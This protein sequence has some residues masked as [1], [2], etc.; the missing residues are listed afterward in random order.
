MKYFH[1][2]KP[3]GQILIA[4]CA[5]SASIA[6]FSGSSFASATGAAPLLYDYEFTGT[7]GTVVNSAPSGPA[8]PLT[9]DGT[10]SPVATGVK[11]SGDT[12]GNESV[13]YGKPTTGYTLSEPKTAAVAVGA[14]IQYQRPASGKC[15][16][17]APNLS[18][19]G[20]FNAK[21]TPTQAKLQLS[22][23]ATNSTQVVVL[24]RFAGALTTAAAQDP[25]VAS[26]LPL[27]SGH[28]Y[29]ISCIKSPDQAGMTTITLNVTPVKTGVTTTD[30]F[31][32]SAL[33][34][35]KSKQFISV[36]N[37][38]PLP[39]PANNTN[40]FN[41]TMTRTVYCAGTTTAVSDCLTTSLP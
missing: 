22:S 27:V 40:Q 4:A 10:W 3:V 29:N 8:V 17:T 13:A 36:G 21:P 39:P 7:T 32:V 1:N 14:R 15:F 28:V 2:L 11:F 30:T 33:G 24:C 6:L 16:A 38:W 12:S 23:C 25:P 41:G 19:I 35:M 26:S 20:L 18:Q 37:T 31:T 5:A 9:L 34:A